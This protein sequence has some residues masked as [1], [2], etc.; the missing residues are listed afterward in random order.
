MDRKLSFD[1]II[2]PEGNTTG[3]VIFNDERKHYVYWNP[4]LVWKKTY[5]DMCPVNLTASKGIRGSIVIQ[6]SPPIKPNS[7]DPDPASYNLYLS[8]GRLLASG[9]TS[10]QYTHSG[11]GFYESYSYY[12]KAVYSTDVGIEESCASNTA[13]GYTQ[14]SSGSISYTND[15]S[16]TVPPG[17]TKVKVCII[18]GGNAGQARIQARAA[19]GKAGQ[20]VDRVIAVAPRATY[21]VH[22]GNGGQR[23]RNHCSNG[24]RGGYS[25][26]GSVVAYPSSY[27]A[28]WGDQGKTGQSGCNKSVYRDGDYRGNLCCSCSYGGQGTI[29]GEGGSGGQSG[30]RCW[31]GICYTGWEPNYNSMGYGAGGGGS[32][33]PCPC[34]LTNYRKSGAGMKG[35]VVV[36][37]GPWVEALN[38]GKSL[39]DLSEKYG[40]SEFQRKIN[41]NAENADLLYLQN[42]LGYDPLDKNNLNT[43]QYSKRNFEYP[44]QTF[45]SPDVDLND[46]F[47]FGIKEITEDIDSLSD[48]EIER[49]IK[50]ERGK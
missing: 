3:D 13:T 5:T 11:L 12:V 10:T 29:Y 9:L 44:L 48:D 14:I 25:S 15:G 40:E 23:S 17:V 30:Y 49:R 19:G 22:V 20:L 34:D 1:T 7:D 32:Y 18:A 28:H 41:P 50:Q 8:N 33:S 39:K 24:F 35:I 47:Q 4:N 42:L 37:W 6:W 36:Y 16:F 21:S 31:S 46:F 38:Q 45:I 26:F 43:I 2:I 27:S